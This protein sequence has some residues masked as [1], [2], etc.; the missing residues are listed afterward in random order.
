MQMLEAVQSSLDVRRPDEHLPSLLDIDF[1]EHVR[2]GR[3]YLFVDAESTFVHF[4]GIDVPEE[5]Q[6][7]FAKARSEGIKGIYVI[8]NKL[9]KTV[10][11]LC[12]MHHW[13]TQI[14]ADLTLVPHTR[15]HRKGSPF[16]LLQAMQHAEIE[17][18]QALM[19]GDKYSDVTAAN[20]GGVYAVKVDRFGWPDH[21]GDR[22]GRRAVDRALYVSGLV[23]TK[24]EPF[25][26]AETRRP[27]KPS[28]TNGVKKERTF[29]VPNVVADAGRIPGFGIPEI[30][31]HDE[32][33]ALMPPPRFETARNV[34]AVVKKALHS[35]R[36]D[37]YLYHNGGDVADKITDLRK[38]T[39]LG[40]A[41][42]Y[43]VGEVIDSK[44]LRRIGSF[45]TLGSLA[46]DAADGPCARKDKRGLKTPERIQGAK[47]DRNVDKEVAV[48]DEI[49]L[50]IS[51]RMPLPD[52]V[53]Q[54]FREYMR[55]KQQLPKYQEAGYDTKATFGGKFATLL[56]TVAIVTSMTEAPQGF[57]NILHHSAT[58]SK[59]ISYLTSP[60]AWRHVRD[61]Q[62]LAKRYLSEEEY[63]EMTA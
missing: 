2:K 48:A 29:K 61:K 17:S 56:Q 33:M 22:F 34:V 54:Q 14:G 45:G 51:G 59:V 40:S 53:V 4:D 1:A 52:F 47:D 57:V 55:V 15:A 11:Q 6:Q 28:A 8:S 3:E 10:D 35:D 50:V 44:F 31:L 63:A 38:K 49:A 24:T 36:L 13:A 62:D 20:L 39:G 26:R 16:M 60:R 42:I 5:M 27:L 30:E 58:A 32:Y 18:Y 7:K 25:V 46:L 21:I 37:E 9:P 41:A 23:T 43:L 12:Q 19:V